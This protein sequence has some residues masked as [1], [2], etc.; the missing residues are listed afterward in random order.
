MLWFSWLGGVVV[1]SP[2]DVA[3]C[4]CCCGGIAAG[5]YVRRGSQLYDKPLVDP[6]A[7][8]RPESRA[9][10]QT[11]QHAAPG[12]AYRAEN[13]AVSVAI[14][15][16]LANANGQHAIPL[17]AAHSPR[18]KMGSAPRTPRTAGTPTHAH[19]HSHLSSSRPESR[20]LAR[21]TDPLVVESQGPVD[22][23]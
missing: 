7:S 2:E 5:A 12:L 1:C 18:G 19:A 11:E 15:S 3:A 10:E 16:P 23:L 13:M 22:I 20:M 4:R 17:P 14:P 6:V 21:E 8:T 9:S